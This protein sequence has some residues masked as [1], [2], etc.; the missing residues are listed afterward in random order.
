VKRV[1]VTGATGFIGRHAAPLLA[2]RGFEVHAAGSKDADLLDPA[3]AESLV[4]RVQPSHLLH[5]AWYAVPGK[6]WTAPE[7]AAWVEASIRLLRVFADTGGERATMSG[8]CAEYDWSGTGVLSEKDAPLRP[9]TY[10]GKCKHALASV[11]EGLAAERGIGFS[12]GRIFFVYGPHE[13]RGRLVSQVAES[14]VKGEPAPTSEG[15]QRRDFLHARDVASAFVALLDS[16]VEGPVNIGS[17]D[18]VPV[19]DVVS[20]IGEAAGRP[21]LVR[22]GEIPQRAGDPP[23]IEA[24]VARLRDEV[25]SRPAI[26]LEEGI[27]ETVEWWKASA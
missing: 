1:L 22:F 7:N 13:Q 3:A 20:L 27:R 18:A 8:S 9:A 16:D 23:L 24:D 10:Y 4:R 2:E 14:L 11:G 25:G 15:T 21:E 19:R 6:F 26:P 17:G 5:F 12:W